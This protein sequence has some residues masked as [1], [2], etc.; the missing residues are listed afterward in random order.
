MCGAGASQ[1]QRPGPARLCI[2][3][4][5]PHH[6]PSAQRVQ[7]DCS[8]QGLPRTS[9]VG[10][11]L[12]P[13]QASS[14]APP[15]TASFP[16]AAQ[17]SG[18]SAPAS[19]RQ[20]ARI[21][22]SPTV[23]G[24]EWVLKSQPLSQPAFAGDLPPTGLASCPPAPVA[25]APR[26][27]LPAS[28]PSTHQSD[29][30]CPTG[31]KSVTSVLTAAP[32]GVLFWF[33]LHSG[34]GAQR[35]TPWLPEQAEACSDRSCSGPGTQWSR[36]ARKAEA[37]R[38]KLHLPLTIPGW[39]MPRSGVSAGWVRQGR[40]APMIPELSPCH[41]RVHQTRSALDPKADASGVSF[42]SS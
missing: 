5:Q 40:T 10:H 1:L 27:I 13:P 31:A 21:H 18:C 33:P 28:L 7:Q 41:Q 23:L 32:S 38:W 34:E 24:R 20:S 22:S 9:H 14:T 6:L 37:G 42:P 12:R 17:D 8:Q 19:H 3:G 2:T 16:H 25:C 4:A 35:P 15:H 39:Q 11:G 26:S 30:G 36:R 29:S